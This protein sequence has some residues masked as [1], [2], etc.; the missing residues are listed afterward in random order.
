MTQNYVF[1]ELMGGYGQRLLRLLGA[2]YYDGDGPNPITQAIGQGRGNELVN[3]GGSEIQLSIAATC[4]QMMKLNSERGPEGDGKPKALRRHWYSWYKSE[5]A[6]PLA[7]ALGQYITTAAG[8]KQINDRKWSS[9][10]SKT[11]GRLVDTGEVTYQDLWVEDASRM[12]RGFWDELFPGVNIAVAV[13]KDSLYGDFVAAAQALGAKALISGKGKQSK[14]A[15]EKL[16]RDHFGWNDRFDR[17]T[18]DQP[19][20]V[21]HVSDY[22]YDGEQVI[23]PTFAEQARRYTPHVDEARIGIQPDQVPTDQWGTR[24]YKVKVSHRGSQDWANSKAL[25]SAGCQ[26]CGHNWLI[27]GTDV[28]S[29]PRCYANEIIIDTDQPG[30]FEVE[31]LT[32]RTFYPYFVDALL[33]LI[34]FTEIVHQLRTEAK[35]DPY[36]AADRVTDTLLEQNDAYQK[37]RAEMQALED[38]LQAFRVQVNDHIMAEARPRQEDYYDQ[39]DDPDPDDF[40]GYVQEANGYTE[41]WRPF[42]KDERTKKLIEDLQEDATVL[43]VLD[44]TF[45]AD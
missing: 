20:R 44:W 2:E 45:E 22:D 37:T 12:M 31:A 23:G 10:L 15:T 38:K 8:V 5:F 27:I 36:Q 34:P 35:P 29:C 30:G 11:Y 1:S 24:S 41:P 4:C 18:D 16:L 25:F 3:D 14:A 6:Q 39:G 13:E 17:F 32:T 43:E 21:I 42:S 19:L 9:L 40:K 7:L 33:S 28:E 26:A